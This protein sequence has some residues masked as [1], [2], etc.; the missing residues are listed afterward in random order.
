MIQIKQEEQAAGGR[1]VAVENGVEIGHLDYEWD[2][3]QCFGITH[4]V[5]EKA[6]EGR[7]IARALLDAS[8]AF[9]RQEKAK[10]RAICPYVAV[11]FARHSSYD[12]VNAEK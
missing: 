5:V 9:A 11:Q 12:D 2:D 3:K 6:F 8:V 10:I 1:F 7:G 4:T